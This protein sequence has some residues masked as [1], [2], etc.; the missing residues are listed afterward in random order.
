MHII[1]AKSDTG[2]PA[3]KEARLNG[4][5][6]T[7]RN[8]PNIMAPAMSIITMHEILRVSFTAFLKLFHERVFLTTLI[9]SAKNDP[10]APAS[11]GVKKPK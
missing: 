4:I 11:E 1:I 7:A 3:T 6:V 5:L 10:A 9:R 2:S 8:L